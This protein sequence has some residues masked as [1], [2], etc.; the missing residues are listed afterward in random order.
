M[1]ARMYQDI[2]QKVICDYFLARYDESMK[3]SEKRNLANKA[4]QKMIKIF[5]KYYNKLTNE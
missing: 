3:A 5:E 2:I 4:S 1:V